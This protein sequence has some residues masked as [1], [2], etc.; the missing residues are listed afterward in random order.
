MA[1]LTIVALVLAA[2]LGLPRAVLEAQEFPTKPVE[3][4]LPFGP[5]GSHDLTARAI[6]SVAHQ[7]LGQ[8][9]L[10]VLKPGG[11]GAVGSQQVIRAKPDGYT[12]LFG[13]TGPNT[14]F[15]LVQKAPIGPEHFTPVARINYSAPFLAVRAEAPWKSL[16]ELVDFAKKN[17][18]KLNFA[19]TGPW[20][21]A[22]LPMRLLG[23]AGGFEYNNIPHD[24]G[25]PSMLAVLG[26]HADATFG[27]T[28]Q[29]TPQLAAGKMRVLGVTDV[30]RHPDFPNIPT[31]KE[32]GFDVVFTMWRTVLAPKGTPPAVLD[33]LESA[34]QKLSDDKSFRALIKS[35]GDEVH[36]QRGKEFEKTWREEWEQHSRIVAGAK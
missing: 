22:D 20:G 19:N 9:L 3:L 32:E 5:G 6:A 18:G 29:L 10:V 12:L 4:V 17:P 1:R 30:K 21:A 36:F 27:F 35:L 23:K 24:G 16:R 8:P 31:M 25:G 2:G 7:Y 14:T 13:G 15:A 34:L 11:G 33:K 28:A 26:G